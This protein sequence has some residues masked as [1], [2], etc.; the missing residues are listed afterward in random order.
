MLTKFKIDHNSSKESAAKAS[1][2]FPMNYEPG[3]QD[4]EGNSKKV[5]RCFK[6][7]YSIWRPGCSVLETLR[8]STRYGRVAPSGQYIENIRLSS[9]PESLA[10]ELQLTMRPKR[11]QFSKFLK[12][13]SFL[14]N[15]ISFLVLGSRVHSRV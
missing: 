14:S 11:H 9:A 4:R 12:V 15:A 10:D 8:V 1:K 6:H 3:A 7:N 13:K 5:A 2:C